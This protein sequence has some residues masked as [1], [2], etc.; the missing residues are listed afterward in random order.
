MLIIGEPFRTLLGL[1]KLRLTGE[2]FIVDLQGELKL[3]FTINNPYQRLK[4]ECHFELHSRGVKW[5][6]NV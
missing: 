6:P 3:S 1:R 5:D 4:D 2:H